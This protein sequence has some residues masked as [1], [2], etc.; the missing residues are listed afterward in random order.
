M[1][2]EILVDRN[3]IHKRVFKFGIKYSQNYYN[4]M[5][6][7]TNLWTWYAMGNL[8]YYL[9]FSTFLHFY[10]KLIILILFTQIRLKLF[11]LI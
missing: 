4:N 5:R 6:L 8:S 10:T 9:V 7:I 1:I 11:I 2:F 3:T